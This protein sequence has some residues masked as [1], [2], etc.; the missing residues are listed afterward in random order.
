MLQTTVSIMRYTRVF[1]RHPRIQVAR[2]HQLQKPSRGAQGDLECVEGWYNPHGRHSALGYLSP[3]AY[4][5]AYVVQ[6]RSR[7]SDQLEKVILISF[8]ERFAVARRL[9]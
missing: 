7:S 6:P 9:N 4:E 8:Q 5:R 1:F 3:I 2:P